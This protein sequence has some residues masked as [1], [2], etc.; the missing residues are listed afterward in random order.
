MT[1]L[2]NILFSI[3]F[4]VLFIQFFVFYYKIGIKMIL[5]P[6]TFFAIIWLFSTFSQKLLMEYDLALVRDYESINELNIFVIVTSIFFSLWMLL[7]KYISYDYKK[8]F[9]FHIDIELYKKFL[10]LMLIG[11]FFQ[12]IYTWYS[13]GVTSFNLEIGRAHV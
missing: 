12:M 4:T 5:H 8:S 9:N 11:A 10:I 13:I 6:G 2:N 7:A 1:G 3:A